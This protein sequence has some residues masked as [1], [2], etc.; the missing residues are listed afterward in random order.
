MARAAA[1]IRRL[2]KQEKVVS[3]LDTCR[4]NAGKGEEI[5]KVDGL[6]KDCFLR[7]VS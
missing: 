3:I 6:K 2:V 4:G 7:W 1:F 5:P